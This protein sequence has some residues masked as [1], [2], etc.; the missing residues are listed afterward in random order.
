[1]TCKKIEMTFDSMLILSKKDSDILPV[2]LFLLKIKD[3]YEIDVLDESLTECSFLV[4]NTEVDETEI[5]NVIDKIIYE[6]FNENISD[7]N[8]TFSVI[9]YN[10]EEN[11]P[12]EKTDSTTEDTVEEKIDEP[13]EDAKEPETNTI[14]KIRNLVG[15]EEFKAL[16]EECLK[17]APNIIK[18]KMSD[19]FVHQSY[20]F[21]I[22][23]GNGLST[24]LELF[25]EL[26]YELKLVDFDCRKNIV[27]CKLPSPNTMER[28]PNPFSCVT[29]CFGTYSK[30]GRIFCIDISEW[31]TKI[32]EKEF[33]DFLSKIE[34]NAANNI[35]IF[36]VPFVEKEILNDIKLNLNDI[37]FIRDV[38]FVPFTNNELVKCAEMS[39]EKRGF[40]MDEDAW[41]VFNTRISEEKNDGKFY[42]INTV[43]KVIC[44][45][46]YIKLLNN[47]D[48]QID[49]N[50]IRK[51]EIFKLA[52][53]YDMVNKKG[54]EILDEFIGM[55]SIKKK[56]EE[57]TTQIETA[58]KNKSL[59]SP[60]I[61]MRFVGNPGTGKTT[62][63]RVVGKILKEKGILRN[64]NF[65]EYSGRDLCGR[66]VGETA[67]KTAS[68]CRDAY[69]S[70]MFIDE[71][72]ALYKGESASSVDYGKEAIDTLI[73]EMENH[74]SDLVVIM[75]GYPEEMDKLLKS[76]VGLESRMPYIIEFPNYTKEQLKEIFMS[77]VN[78]SFKYKDDFLPAVEEYFSLLSDDVIN[79]K[80]FSNARFVRNLFERT[81]GK[82]A[83]RSQIAK[84]DEIMLTKED[85]ILATSEKEFDKIIKKRSVTLGFA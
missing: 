55:E 69:G 73:A 85:F 7:G 61:H 25:S 20:L 52:N 29:D 75:A 21:S 2:S 72:Y 79:S 13:E 48:N 16:A 17:I 10:S 50:I 41:E 78:K 32:N 37:L 24:Y 31:M 47:A 6:I 5:K 65:F 19:V 70:V 14:D 8:V 53:T 84:T 58:V 28:N 11:K 67:P 39:L 82:A 76:N 27:E 30:K 4:K 81:W 1:M 3:I 18:Y 42:G 49:D 33:K 74:R 83:M 68:M 56:V 51:D 34:D 77:M 80:E 23:N 22:N 36:R 35:F 15:A 60:C 9:E 45:M 38:S 12:E 57:I 71:A 66:Y 44:E 63:A 54:I 43:N 59:G 26:I 40:V 62:V 64:G 46:I